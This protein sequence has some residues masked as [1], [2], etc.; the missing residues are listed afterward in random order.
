MFRLFQ[1]LLQLLLSR[2]YVAQVLR[3]RLLSHVFVK[4]RATEHPLHALGVV[5]E[6]RVSH[7]RNER[8]YLLLVRVL[9]AFVV[10]G[11]RASFEGPPVDRVL[12]GVVAVLLSNVGEDASRLVAR[13]SQGVQVV[14]AVDVGLIPVLQQSVC[15]LEVF[16]DL[17]DFVRGLLSGSKV[18]FF[19]R[20]F[21]KVRG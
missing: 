4:V 21:T 14:D 15:A 2:A 10:R 19:R 18:W 7:L 6:S 11:A 3:R 1:N 16:G 13:A 17:V 12:N 5:F 8:V 9:V 20:R